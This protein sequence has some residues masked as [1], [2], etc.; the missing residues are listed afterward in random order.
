MSLR[1]LLAV[2]SVTSM[3][4]VGAP[5]LGQPAAVYEV[6]DLGTLGGT[7]SFALGASERGE[8]VGT[9]RTTASSRPQYAFAW[10]EG[11]MRALEQLEG[12]TF[13]RAFAVN[14]RGQAVGE[15]FTPSP[16]RS[17]AV[18]WEAD[19]RVEDL[20]TLDGA[21][22]AVAND[23]NARGQVAGVSGARAVVWDAGDVRPV[24]GLSAEPDARSRAEAINEAGA[25]AGSAQTDLVTAGGWRVTHA[26]VATPRGGT[27]VLTDLGSAGG[28]GAYS[29]ALDLNDRGDAVGESATEAGAATYRATLWA[30]GAIIDLGTV[31]GLRHSRASS[32]NNRRQVVGHASGFYGFPTIDGVAVLWQAGQAIDLNT[33]IPAGSGWTLR[34]AQ[35]ITERGEIVGYGTR[36]GQTRAFLLRP[37][38]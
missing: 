4:A 12:S 32:V 33:L 35:T 23:L 34:H 25:V 1:I 15:A 17:R 28:P 14:V 26:F 11:T 20:G 3:L 37:R 29:T 16:E 21:S 24:G 7:A 31:A 6:V 19:G 38:A 13:S 27:Y 36:D 2:L 30:D 9:S 10:R 18:R 5:A 22:G 8:V